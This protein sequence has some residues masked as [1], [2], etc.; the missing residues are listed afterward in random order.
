MNAGLIADVPQSVYLTELNQGV[1]VHSMNL[2]QRGKTVLILDI[3][4]LCYVAV[5]L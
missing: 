5:V 3:P 4:A 1:H 2:N